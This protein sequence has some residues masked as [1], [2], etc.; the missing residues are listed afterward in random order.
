VGRVFD[1][2]FKFSLVLSLIKSPFIFLLGNLPTTTLS[3]N[4]IT[5][6]IL[7]LSP[8][9]RFTNSFI[10]LIHF[11]LLGHLSPSIVGFPWLPISTIVQWLMRVRSRDLPIN[12][13]LGFIVYT[14]KQLH[15]RSSKSSKEAKIRSLYQYLH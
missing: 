9:F 7:F 5:S 10:F 8:K 11:C 12:A 14:P 2:K 4:Y 3:S 15:N 13:S 6:L 1:H